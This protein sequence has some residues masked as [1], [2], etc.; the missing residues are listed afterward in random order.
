MNPQ[1][2]VSVSFFHVFLQ[3][4]H[5]QEF[6]TISG[7]RIFA[8]ILQKPVKNFKIKRVEALTIR[9]H[10]HTHTRTLGR[11]WCSQ[12]SPHSSSFASRDVFKFLQLENDQFVVKKQN[13]P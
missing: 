9:K 7:G 6:L 4:L 12:L 3:I 1:G 5:I 10:T 2:I 8:Q 13:I 11:S